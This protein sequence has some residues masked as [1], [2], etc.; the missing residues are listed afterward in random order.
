MFSI[1]TM[2]PIVALEGCDKSI[3]Y[4]Q[5]HHYLLILN[6]IDILFIIKIS[7]RKNLGNI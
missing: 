2:G 1:E 4:F 6:E 7:A 5:M 3:I